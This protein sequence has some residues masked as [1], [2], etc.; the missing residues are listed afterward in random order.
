[1]HAVANA[2]ST[3][4]LSFFR[5]IWHRMKYS[6]LNEMNS[7]TSTSRP[8]SA[9]EAQLPSVSGSSTTSASSIGNR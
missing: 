5:C 9:C 7:Y 6:A 3:Y 1:M 2:N 8:W 4:V